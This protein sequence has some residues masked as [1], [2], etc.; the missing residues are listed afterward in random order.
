LSAP[1]RFEA[2]A[3]PAATD[4]AYAAGLVDG[5]GCI[6]ITR[7]F[8]RTSDRYSDGVAVVVVNR[9]REVLDWLRQLWSGWVVAML[10]PQSRVRGFESMLRIATIISTINHR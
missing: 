7:F 8:S 6:A 10:K 9:D 1:P 2:V 5:E 4:W 3:E